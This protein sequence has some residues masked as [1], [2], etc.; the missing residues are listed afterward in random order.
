MKDLADLAWP[1]E[2]ATDALFDL[3]QRA[4]LRPRE[5]RAREEA[6]RGSG[7]DFLEA[8]ASEMDLEAEPV[9]VAYAEAESFLAR[10]APALVRIE[11]FE[12]GPRLLLVIGARGG[13]VRVLAPDLRVVRV[14]V[15]ELRARW[16]ARLEAAYAPMVEP[17][18]DTAR[19]SGRARERAR[20]AILAEHL[21]AVAVGGA[22]LVR[23][24]PGRSLL[25]Q[26][27]RAG[28]GVRI[29]A[30]VVASLIASALGLVAWIALGRGALA[31][32]FEPAA[33]AAWALLLL[34][35]IPLRLVESWLQGAVAIRAGALFKR[36]L[37]A[38]ATR[39]DPEDVRGEGAGHLLG[40][41][42][43]AEALEA[44]ALGAGFQI[45]GAA[46]DVPLAIFALASG[47]SPGS[48][49][50]LFGTCA[51]VAVVLALRHRARS[52][53]FAD[54]RLAMTQDLVERMVGH[55]TRIA[56]E[57]PSRWHLAEDRLL[58]RYLER[59]RELDATSLTLGNVLT[60]AWLVAGL[61]PLLAAFVGGTASPVAIA[62]GLGGVILGQQALSKLTAGLV[63][64]STCAVAWRTVRPLF[65]AAARRDQPGLPPALLERDEH[66]QSAALVEARGITFRFP[67]RDRAVLENVDVAIAPGA[68]VLVTGPS[69]GGKSTLASLL[70]GWRESTAGLLF[71]LGLDRK[72][73][74]TAA[75]RARVAAAPQFHENHVF[76]GTLAFNLLMGSKHARTEDDHARARDVLA[77]LGLDDVVRRMPS[78]LQQIVGETGWQLSHGEKSRIYIARALL[79]GGDLVVLDESFAALDPHSLRAAFDCVLARS[80][81]LV[82]VAHP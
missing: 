36:R 52:R 75:W 48:S 58:E 40:R 30:V 51:L 15:S 34:S 6:G 32:R 38:G 31:G 29:A 76:T 61:V 39:L 12:G 41:V 13:H 49:L 37:L 18:L 4:G 70:I 2:R 65:E 55:R 33:I 64:V 60:A 16:C 21:G 66:A 59:S 50:A 10:A 47:P 74:G 72:S 9:E 28:L 79:Q 54:A 17:V 73:H 26:A 78:G 56:Q 22:W 82:V 44:Q 69:G 5:P 27:H 45:L 62:I 46:I 57:D 11:G 63:Q 80:K 43:E 24:P 3:A 71:L 8:T 20:G 23:L 42:L 7:T 25:L 53:R 1:I 68:R 67:S 77:E 35:V 81:G 19:L 14:R